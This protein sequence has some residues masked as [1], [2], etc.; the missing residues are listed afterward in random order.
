MSDK[1]SDAKKVI[2]GK[3]GSILSLKYSIAMVHKSH[4]SSVTFKHL[5]ML[6]LFFMYR[7][8]L[9]TSSKICNKHLPLSWLHE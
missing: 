4:S 9:Y 7:R 8:M 2:S 5:V 6:G 1:K 3:V